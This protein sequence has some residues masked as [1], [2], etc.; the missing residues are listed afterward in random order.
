MSPARKVLRDLR[1]SWGEVIAPAMRY[2][3]GDAGAAAQ[4]G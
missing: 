3:A 2:A 1:E 4:P